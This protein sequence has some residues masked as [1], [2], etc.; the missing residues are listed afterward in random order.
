MNF[1]DKPVTER[2]KASDFPQP[3]A[4]DVALVRSRLASFQDVTADTRAPSVNQPIYEARRGAAVAN[5][6]DATLITPNSLR[7]AGA[8]PGTYSD[9]MR[10]SVSLNVAMQ[11]SMVDTNSTRPLSSTT[12]SCASTSPVV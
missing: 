11:L 10:G 12:T 8:S 7:L 2:K 4:D 9:G 3:S 1:V 6:L 5:G